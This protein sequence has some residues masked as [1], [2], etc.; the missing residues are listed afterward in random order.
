MSA[1][2]QPGLLAI[3][4]G[5]SRVKLGWFPSEL[6]C[7]SG[8]VSGPF[9]IAVPRLPEPAE[10]FACRHRDVPPQVFSAQIRHW[11]EEFVPGKPMVA[12]AS[13]SPEATNHILAELA[14]SGFSHVRKLEVGDLPIGIDLQ[15]PTRVGI[16]RILS[17]VAVNRIRAANTP[18]IVISLGTACTVNLISAEGVFEGGAILPGLTMAANALHGGTASLP[19][20]L[21]ESLQLPANAIGKN[22]HEAMSA[23]VY[24]GLIGAIER[25]VAEQSQSFRTPP[26]LFFT[27]GE[28]PLLIDG[29]IHDVYAVRE[30][31]H[32]VLAGIAIACEARLS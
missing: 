12:I 9:P 25:I 24:W 29:L 14:T 15:E 5:T 6:A 32:L 20:I 19:L 28:G 1:A 7:P 13:V 16:D 23:G 22:T 2:T 27:G 18:A 21:P 3:D 30:V 31:P 10:T 11:L 17:S 26:Q 8:G 4:V